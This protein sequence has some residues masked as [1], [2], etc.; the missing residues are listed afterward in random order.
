[1]LSRLTELSG[2]QKDSS[3]TILNRQGMSHQIF[4]TPGEMGL[5]YGVLRLAAALIEVFAGGEDVT[6]MSLLV[7]RCSRIAY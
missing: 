5:L 7:E 1:M 2:R 3:K 6:S 4:T